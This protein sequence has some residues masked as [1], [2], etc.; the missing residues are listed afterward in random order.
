M[1]VLI[2]KKVRIQ[3]LLFYSERLLQ[4]L[5]IHKK[6]LEWNLRELL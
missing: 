1:R 3:F 6:E 2:G 5:R 4:L